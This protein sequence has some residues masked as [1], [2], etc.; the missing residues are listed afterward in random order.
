MRILVGRMAVERMVVTR[1][2]AATL[3]VLEGMGPAQP[4]RVLGAEVGVLEV[5]FM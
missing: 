3:A 2:V 1:E 5:L 4:R